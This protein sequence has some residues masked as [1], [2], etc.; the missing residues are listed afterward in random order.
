MHEMLS[1][2]DRGHSSKLVFLNFSVALYSVNH[3]ALLLSILSSLSI[4]TKLLNVRQERVHG[5]GCFGLYSSVLS[6]V[7]Q[8]I[9]LGS[10]LSNIAICGPG[11][12]IKCRRMLILLS[13]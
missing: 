13:S 12:L 3:K 9:V 8:S 10:L 1:A 11:S 4:L 5:D 7:P 6:E 2:L